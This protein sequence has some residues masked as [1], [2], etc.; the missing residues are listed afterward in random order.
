[1]ML[2]QEHK[3]FSR[4]GNATTDMEAQL[5]DV[6]PQTMLTLL[7]THHHSLKQTI[8]GIFMPGTSPTFYKICVLAGLEYAFIMIFTQ[9]IPHRC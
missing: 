8:L 4:S 5:V 2:I 6:S 7:T 1:M 3:H 9:S